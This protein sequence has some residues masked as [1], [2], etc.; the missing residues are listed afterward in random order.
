M[1]S[2][3]T[4]SRTRVLSESAHQT[5]SGLGEDVPYHGGCQTIRCVAL[6]ESSS[7][8][9]EASVDIP[10]I[11]ESTEA[12]EFLGFSA[13]AAAAILERFLDG[14]K[15]IPDEDILDYAKGHVRSAPDAG[16]VEDDWNSAMASMGISQA[17]RDQ[18]LDPKFSELRLTRNAQFLVLDTIE[19]K[20]MF[21]SSL[22]TNVLGSKPTDQGLIS[23]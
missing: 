22:D 21:L 4:S 6:S 2:S 3:A 1:S 20:F 16:T 8:D 14:S 17:L 10:Q 19:A 18:I 5:L 12:M 15:N 9:S 7:S 11:L 13:G 23:L